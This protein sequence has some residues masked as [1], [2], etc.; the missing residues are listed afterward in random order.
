MR[1]F[2]NWRSYEMDEMEFEPLKFDLQG[3]SSFQSEVEKTCRQAYINSIKML[4]HSVAD[5]ALGYVTRNPK[6]G[7]EPFSDKIRMDGSM[8]LPNETGS[9]LMFA[10]VY[11]QR[12]MDLYEAYIDWE[13]KNDIPM[14]PVTAGQIKLHGFSSEEIIEM[15]AGCQIYSDIADQI[16]DI[17]N[18]DPVAFGKLIK[19][20]T[21]NHQDFSSN[22]INRKTIKEKLAMDL[23][24]NKVKELQEQFK[25]FDEMPDLQRKLI[26]NAHFLMHNVNR[27]EYID[28]AEQLYFV[29]IMTPN[30]SATKEERL[31]MEIW[32]RIAGDGSSRHQNVSGRLGGNPL[33]YRNVVKKGEPDNPAAEFRNKM[34][35]VYMS[36]HFANTVINSPEKI[37][38]INNYL[39]ENNKGWEINNDFVN[40]IKTRGADYIPPVFRYG[41][42]AALNRELRRAKPDEEIAEYYRN[43]PN[44]TVKQAIQGTADL[45]AYYRQKLSSR[46]L[47]NQIGEYSAKNIDPNKRLNFE[48][49]AAIFH[50]YDKSSVVTDNPTVKKYLEII[51]ELSLPVAAGIS[52]TLDQSTTMAGLV[53]LGI[54]QDLKIR[55]GELQ[56]IK[57]SYLAHM[58]LTKGHSVHEIMQSSKT[59]GL[60]YVPGANASSY[61]YP[62]DQNYVQERLELLQQERGTHLPKHF[63]TN[64]FAK[65][66]EQTLIESK[67]PSAVLDVFSQKD[68][69]RKEAENLVSKTTPKSSDPGLTC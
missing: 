7:L 3:V 43:N 57:L 44:I 5:L 2:S 33:A 56:T 50:L 36:N 60:T 34:Y 35:F 8:Q 9:I 54:D 25:K 55:E 69:Q 23:D 27:M 67:L 49:G 10:S 6:N 65:E 61:I 21:G 28:V 20:M 19:V 42:N 24:E 63:L 47:M 52:G 18:Y 15:Q 26:N 31:N 29:G 1:D 32:H 41:A 64:E 12:Y 37:K 22:D 16:L 39:K 48:A 30:H 46:E 53:G 68:V 4:E 13:M 11:S 58:V 51:D 14:I 38:F 62:L 45:N 59:F 66:V 40:A 17:V